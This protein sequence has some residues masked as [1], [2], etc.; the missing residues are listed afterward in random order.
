MRLMGIN[1]GI[2]L[3]TKLTKEV[4]MHWSSGYNVQ[5]TH[6]LSAWQGGINLFWR[7]SEMN[8]IKEVELHGSN[9]LSF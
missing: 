6:V 5:S 1:L 4:Y 9:V 7:A 3:E 2:L 8:E